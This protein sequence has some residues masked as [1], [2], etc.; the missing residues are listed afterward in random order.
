MKA[1]L[2]ICVDMLMA[3]WNGYHLRL[4]HG[5]IFVLFSLSLIVEVHNQFVLLCVGQ[6]FLQVS[7]SPANS[8]LII[9][10]IILID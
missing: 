10:F 1:G 4:L 7:K 5:L 9:N 2:D 8:N 6:H 3:G